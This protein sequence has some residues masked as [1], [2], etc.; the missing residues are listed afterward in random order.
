MSM[1]CQVAVCLAIRLTRHG[2]RAQLPSASLSDQPGSTSG[3][4]FGLY[5]P[6]HGSAPD[7]AGNAKANPAGTILSAALMLRWSLGL[8]DAAAAVER[9]VVTA[10]AA[11]VR[12][13]DIVEPGMGSVTTAQFG[14]EVARR[15]EMT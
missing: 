15:V 13:P 11:G 7:I 8:G 10:I 2:L 3:T 6:I 9:A 1:V 5:E 4:R 12:T 14:D